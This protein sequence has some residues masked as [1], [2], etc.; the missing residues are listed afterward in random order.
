M[1][2]KNSTKKILR[3]WFGTCRF[4][5]NSIN[6]KIKHKIDDLKINFQSLR[7]KFVT[8]KNNNL[9]EWQKLVPKEVRAYSVKELVNAYTSNIN[10]YKKTKK[11]FKINYKPKNFTKETITLPKESIKIFRSYVEIY[12]TITKEKIWINEKRKLT[13]KEQK[14]KP[15][16]R[17]KMMKERIYEDC[18]DYKITFIKP[19]RWYLLIPI[20]V[21]VNEH[22][23]KPKICALDPGFRTFMTGADLNG[24]CFKIGEGAR[25]KLMEKEKILDNL[26]SKISI[27][28]T[29]KNR[30]GYMKNKKEFLNLH[31]KCKNLIDE[32]HNKA[33]KYLTDK[34]D[35]III[36]QMHTNNMHKKFHWFNR[37]LH[38]LNH[39]KFLEKLK[40]KCIML[41]KKLIITDEKY[42]TKTCCSCG[43][44][45]NDVGT[46]KQ[47]VCNICKTKIDRDINGAINILEK[48]ICGC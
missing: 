33:I 9:P 14:N 17:E 36:P 8:A 6:Y 12:K 39:S 13:K 18:C 28:K 27:K 25:T 4:L 15:K 42:T 7:N 34:Y 1:K 43:F 21:K 20:K 29:T 10:K 11:P 24:N 35:I 32:L 38:S 5:Y 26:Q 47:Y 31:T 46:S 44:I 48:T 3:H 22:K 40:N 2:L 23:L 37:M 30:I 45:K 16:N 41:G 19:N